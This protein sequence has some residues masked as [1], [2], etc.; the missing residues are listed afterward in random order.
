MTP[1][2][3]GAWT[4]TNS[5]A[6]FTHHELLK[7]CSKL[8]WS[9]QII[10]FHQP[11]FPWNNG[12]SLTKPPFGVRS[13]EVAIIWP[14]VIWKNFPTPV[15][16]LRGQFFSN[17]QKNI[18]GPRQVIGIPN[19]LHPGRLTWNL[20]ITY[21]KRKIIFQTSIIMFHVNLPG[22]T[23][24]GH[25]TSLDHSLKNRRTKNYR[26]PNPSVRKEKKMT[27]KISAWRNSTPFFLAPPKSEILTSSCSL[28]PGKSSE[29]KNSL[30]VCAS[31]WSARTLSVGG[32]LFEL[33][34]SAPSVSRLPTSK[35]K[36]GCSSAAVACIINTVRKETS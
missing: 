19:W 4:K 16:I 26:L 32:L 22:C 28:V 35:R 15:P 11:R 13:C 9:G 14:E 27:H 17:T 12:I 34:T 21:L 18:S 6:C 8:K 25:W 2:N 24:I 1:A 29:Q 36:K 5:D 30:G 31:I 20:K 33:P 7:D 10:I 3:F 23:F